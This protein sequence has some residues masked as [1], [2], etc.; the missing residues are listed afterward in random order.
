MDDPEDTIGPLGVWNKKDGCRR[1][2]SGPF[3][4]VTRKG[5]LREEGHRK[6]N[7]FKIEVLS[8][9]R[10]GNLELLDKSGRLK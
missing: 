10:G 2:S 8:K 4:C 3:G 5:D 9:N 1:I 6:E 7:T